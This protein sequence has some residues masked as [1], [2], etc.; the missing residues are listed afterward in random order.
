M[1]ASVLKPSLDARPQ[2]VVVTPTSES[3]KLEN[4]FV[5]RWLPPVPPSRQLPAARG[6]ICGIYALSASEAGAHRAEIASV[7][8][9]AILNGDVHETERAAGIA[10]RVAYARSGAEVPRVRVAL[11]DAD[12]FLRL[13]EQ[14]LRVRGL[15]ELS[16]ADRMQQRGNLGAALTSL[17]LIA[18]NRDAI[19]RNSLNRDDVMRAL[20]HEHLHVVHAG[21][22]IFQAIDAGLVVPPT[23]PAWVQ[24]MALSA[25][26]EGHA[27][28]F[29][30]D[31]SLYPESNPDLSAYRVAKDQWVELETLRSQP[32]VQERLKEVP[33]AAAQFTAAERTLTP[34]VDGY[35]T[36]AALRQTHPALVDRAFNE[37]WVAKL[38]F[39]RSGTVEVPLP[40][41]ASQEDERALRSEVADILRFNRHSSRIEVAVKRCD[42]DAL[43]PGS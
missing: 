33:E 32:W 3:G 21:F 14:E 16:E 30:A 15:P 28:S 19:V 27:T 12:E 35:E 23:D 37:P 31:L 11:C 42:P 7:D 25:L 6:R 41:G 22:G 34:Y 4:A 36:V 1:R 40:A 20:E 26:A 29:D 24:G 5:D 2:A 18:L 43:H 38:L 10:R 17:G 39:V 9:D 8:L 13:Q